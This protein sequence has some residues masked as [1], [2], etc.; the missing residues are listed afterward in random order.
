[1]SQ[2]PVHFALVIL[3]MGGSLELFPWAGLD[4]DPLELSLPSSLHYK[5]EL[6]APQL[7]SRNFSYRNSNH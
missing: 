4:C 2:T 5:L 1:L 6:L 3:E 7:V